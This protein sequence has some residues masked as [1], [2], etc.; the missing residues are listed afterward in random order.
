MRGPFNFV[1]D[2]GC[3]ICGRTKGE[4]PVGAVTEVRG[5]PRDGEGAWLCEECS[6]VKRHAR[7]FIRF[8]WANY[9]VYGAVL[10]PKYGMRRL[11]D[12]VYSFSYRVVSPRLTADKF[13]DW[14]KDIWE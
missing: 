3:Y 12:T 8:A 6:Q 11:P 7:Q 10:P 5:G 13:D 14:V 1:H 4:V 9:G 2:R